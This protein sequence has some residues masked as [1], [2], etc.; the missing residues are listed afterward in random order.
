MENLFS[1]TIYEEM[2]F[3]FEFY[4]CNSIAILHFFEISIYILSKKLFFKNIT[5][6]QKSFFHSYKIAIKMNT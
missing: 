4:Y 1:R 2:Y 6:R 3:F 5:K